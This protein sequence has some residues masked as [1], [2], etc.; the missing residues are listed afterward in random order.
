MGRQAD[1]LTVYREAR[2]ALVEELGIEPSP[3][4]QR[5][6]AAVL[7][8]D[9]SLDYSPPAE[10]RRLEDSVAATA[11][12]ASR[13][14]GDERKL[15]TALFA[16]LRSAGAA[17][18]DPERARLR[19]DRFW[20][21]ATTEIEPLGG[22]VER[23]AGAAVTAV[24]GAPMALEDHAER[25]LHAALKLKERVG[26][27]FGDGV[28]LRIGTESGEVLVSQPHPGGSVLAGEAVDEA[29]RLGHAA[30]PG[31][32]LVGK[33]SA[34]AVGGAFELSAATT[35]G[36]EGLAGRRL[37]RGLSVKRPRGVRGLPP[38][39]VG[40]EAELELLKV[41]YRRAVS[42]HAP[43]LVTVVGEAGVGKTRLASELSQRLAGE[44]PDLLT[45]TG[46]C[47]SYGRGITYWPLGEILKEELGL[48]E[49]DSKEVVR[50]MLGDRQTLG[51]AI[52]LEPEEAGHPLQTREQL[53]AAWV[54]WVDE[55]VQVRPA[56]L[57][58]EDLHW[59]EDPL[60]DLLGRLVEEVRGPLVLLGTA[61]PE[62]L[63][64]R[65][66]WGSGSRDSAMVRL[67]PLQPGE[68]SRL[69]E[70]LFG[71]EVPGGAREWVLAHA[72]G[73]PF[74]V[75][76][77]IGGLIDRGMLAQANGEW[78]LCELPA[79]L[80]IPGSVQA[81]LASR[82]DLLPPEAKAALQA[83]SVIGRVFRPGQVQALLEGDEP[84]LA[85]LEVRDFI[86]RRSGPPVAGEHE[87][88]IKHALTREVAYGTL[89]K[90]RR[91]HLH[92]AFATWLEGV[93]EGRDELV[94]FL[95]HHFFESVRP[96][97]VDLVWDRD[98]AEYVRL[99]KK[100]VVWLRRAAD[101]AAARGATDEALDLLHRALTLV[102]RESE[103]VEL[104]QVIGHVY[105]LK[106]DG[107]A[108]W[109]A[110]EK[111]LALGPDPQTQGRIYSELSYQTAT[112]AG[113]W[114]RAPAPGVVDGWIERAL[115]LTEAESLAR[116]TALVA[117]AS[118]PPQ[119]ATA[120]REALALSHRLG[121]LELRSF[122]FQAK[123][124]LARLDKDFETAW[125][126]VERRLQ[127]LHGID[128]PD[129][130]ADATYQGVVALAG[131]GRMH[132]ARR[133]AQQ[134]EEISAKLTPHH[135][136]HSVEGLAMVE[137]LAGGW[138]RLSELRP[139]IELA[140]EEN[141]ATPCRG[142]ERSLLL[143]ALAF[144]HRGDDD[145]ARRLERRADDIGML[146]YGRSLS[147][148]RLAL[149]LLRRELSTVKR[150]VDDPIAEHPCFTL[151]TTVTRLDALAALRDGERAEKE[152][153]PLLRP[154]TYLEPFALRTLGLVRESQE[155][156]E[157]AATHFDAAGLSW[158]AEHTRAQSWTVRLV[159][160]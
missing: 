119:A 82:M 160:G 151:A 52:G 112:R 45:R 20:S 33:R 158:H 48:V 133:L 29:A 109:T 53:H 156:L 32:I 6:Q 75:E 115:E 83:A 9:H 92:A 135:R 77:L 122:A 41:T 16:E 121:D 47:L 102:E 14:P 68:A 94:P 27:L 139:V 127:L 124:E 98:R 106:Y 44:S 74:F 145:T 30:S 39:F 91:A 67:E 73:N 120:A 87:Y 1:A 23:F 22:T 3:P 62:L 50:R 59:A 90:A 136:L 35:A 38:V 130:R 42:G 4:L 8:Q 31:E 149:A 131:V 88:V 103:R 18:G 154:G 17:G 56:L 46:R 69:V 137:Q 36:A 65:P 55:L 84:D 63:S 101:L 159:A 140:V 28:V 49:G 51:L 99:S 117:R 24:F 123:A 66:G 34:T 95:A 72:E 144:A 138:E 107:Q 150:L 153:R 21:A 70:G 12:V 54:S 126:W 7:G 60:L 111:A 37:V 26:A 118:W 11:A 157:Q 143:C 58:I 93:G 5:L 141:R 15:A 128:D 110:M 19:F 79:D 104:W 147:A 134:L 148:P 113:M 13:E 10:P 25:A 146:G 81:A 80:E 96:E 64:R 116:G 108:F 132:E 2:A 76:E 40:R 61:R 43:C 78:G 152:A 129:H 86:R 97:D 125:S 85:P 57:L 105:A 155:L 142:N 114:H 89:T 100:A 71:G